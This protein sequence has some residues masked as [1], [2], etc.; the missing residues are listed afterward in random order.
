MTVTIWRPGSPLER[1]SCGMQRQYHDRVSDPHD[2]VP[3]TLADYEP[4]DLSPEQ[5]VG[6]IYRVPN[7]PRAVACGDELRARVKAVMGV[8]HEDLMEAMA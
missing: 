2:F 7:S 1:C 6:E 8:D 3:E 4:G 5:L